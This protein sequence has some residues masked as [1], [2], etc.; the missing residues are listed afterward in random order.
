MNRN[1]KI[2]DILK[3]YST[4]CIDFDVYII[5]EAQIQ[6][7]TKSD[8]RIMHAD[9]SEFFSRTE[10][11]E[12]ASAIFNVFGFAKVFYDE[13]SFIEYIIHNKVNTN[14]C[15][16]YNLS[17]NGKKQ[18]KKSLIPAFCDLY[19]IRYTGSD[20]F[21]ISLLRN[22]LMYSNILNNYGINVPIMLDFNCNQKNKEEIFDLFENKDIIIKNNNESASIGL[23]P[24]CKMKLTTD[25]YEKLCEIAKKV[26]PNNVLVQE[27]IKG[28]EYEVLVLQ[29]KGKYYALSPIEIILPSNREFLDTTISNSY[30]YQFKEFTDLEAEIMCKTAEKASKILGIKDY[31][32]FDFR[33]RDGIPYLF[34]IAGTPYTVR[35]SSVAYLFEIAKYT[36]ED[37]YKVIITCMLSN[38]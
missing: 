20:A 12:I 32:R 26:N 4:H 8:K 18:G 5:A 31:A 38:Y 15:I 30:N 7:I 3:D 1:E 34:D 17:R 2:N 27:Y 29:H 6:T 11:A 36:Y 33:V 21:V 35:H 13:V 28:K 37:I 10:F 19:G 23:V 16:V 22:K 24:E 14:G 9:E 25:S